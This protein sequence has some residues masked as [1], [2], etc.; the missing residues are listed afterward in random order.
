M[1]K[2]F[3]KWSSGMNSIYSGQELFSYKCGDMKRFKLSHNIKSL[4]LLA[5]ALIAILVY[6]PAAGAWTIKH[7]RFLIYRKLTDYIV[8]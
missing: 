4:A 5:S 3:T 2:C 1:F 6:F 8:S 7:H